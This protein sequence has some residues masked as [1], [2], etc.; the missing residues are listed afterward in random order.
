[1][2]EELDPI[3]ENEIRQISKQASS[4]IKIYGKDILPRAGEYKPEHILYALA[5]I[6]KES[7]PETLKENA[8]NFNSS[9][10]DKRIPYFSPGCP[11]RAVFYAV[12]EVLA[13]D[14]VYGGDI[15]CYL[16]GA[17]PRFKGEDFIVSMGR[18]VA[19]SHGIA[20]TN[21]EKPVTFKGILKVRNGD[22][23]ISPG[24]DGAYG[25]VRIL[26]QK[27]RQQAQMKLF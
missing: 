1:V 3:V 24:Y 26:E 17:L 9:Q 19:I 12:R 5:K 2:V 7:L 4:K 14:K 10:V 21:K 13:K 27:E 22:V 6:Y 16:L 18:G 15:G 8:K 25:K 20:K 11:H 23:H